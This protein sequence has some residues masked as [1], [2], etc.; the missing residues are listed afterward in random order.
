M[1]GDTGGG[2]AMLDD[3]AWDC[4]LAWLGLGGSGSGG[5][6]GGMRMDGLVKGI[7]I[8]R[9]C[10]YCRC[11][12]EELLW[13]VK[14]VVVVERWSRDRI[15]TTVGGKLDVKKRNFHSSLHHD[16]EPCRWDFKSAD[17]VY[18]WALICNSISNHEIS[19]DCK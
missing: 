3:D 2:E 13:R 17:V 11:R 4:G 19:S 8:W 14:S 5:S 9:K 18:T 7:W 6:G 16:D 12:R 15:C 10:C 1:V